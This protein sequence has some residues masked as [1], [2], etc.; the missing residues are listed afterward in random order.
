MM[1]QAP[2][3][4]ARRLVPVVHEITRLG[5]LYGDSIWPGFRPDTIPMSFVIPSH[6][7]FLYGWRGALP[8]G[9][10]PVDGVPELAWRDLRALGAASTGTSLEG[11]PVAQIVLD[12]INEPSL[13][14]IAFHEAFHVFQGVSRKPGRR[15]GSGE[16]SFYVAS[17]AIFDS[18]NETGFAMEAAILGAALNISDVRRKRDL[19]QQLVAVRR[20]R[21]AG[22]SKEMSDF[23][24][25]S[26]LNE[27]LAQYALVRTLRLLQAHGPA[28]WRPQTAAL[29][30]E[31][32][33]RIPGIMTNTKQSFRLRYYATGSSM[34][35][36]MDDLSG[37]RWKRLIADENLTIQDALGVVSGVDSVARAARQRAEARFDVAARRVEAA[38]LMARI[39]ST[40]MRQ[41]DSVL[42]APGITVVVAADSLPPRQF[43]ICSFDPQNHLQVSATMQLQT[44][45]W[46]PCIGR[47]LRA[48]F[49][50]P[51]VHDQTAMTVTAVIGA[52]ADI[53]LTVDGQAV[54]L[55]P[56]DVLAAVTNVKLDAPRASVTAAKATVNR[57]GD[58]ITIRGLP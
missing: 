53:K 50:V 40:R 31:E 2:A 47:A 7:D 29:L 5:R 44:R 3:D 34:G 35:L 14:S 42:A 39:S 48:E 51:S 57:V 41:V 55:K 4:T 43:G 58:R 56:G 37:P 36:I 1:A 45:M 8:G 18:A 13:V 21:H 49:N 27:G 52:E 26:E 12:A 24:Q 28:A 9:Y 23:D 17:Y 10:A 54:T 19:A 16:N 20:G 6:G 11:R 46:I 30:R 33:E 22:I 15:F 38:A 25:Q 32:R